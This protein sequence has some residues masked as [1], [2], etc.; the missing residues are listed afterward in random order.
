[1]LLLWFLFLFTSV[2]IGLSD[3]GAHNVDSNETK[4]VFSSKDIDLFT[5]GG[6]ELD[7]NQMKWQ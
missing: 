6:G 1:M 2:C 5:S 7:D 3:W 4:G